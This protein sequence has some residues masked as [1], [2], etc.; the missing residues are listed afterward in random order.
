MSHKKLKEIV[1]E[2]QPNSGKSPLSSEDPQNPFTIAFCYPKDK[3]PFV[4]K[5]GWVDVEK[6]IKSQ[7]DPLV[8]HITYWWRKAHRNIVEAYNTTQK[9]H[10]EEMGKL[11]ERKIWKIYTYK[12]I[13]HVQ[14]EK[15]VLAVVR[16]LPRKWIKELNSY[17]P[18]PR[19]EHRRLIRLEVNNEY[20]E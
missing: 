4:I 9:I 16:R 17:C 11:G 2:Y 20:N 18:I 13:N 5:G 6:R 3:E 1:L 14:S 15:K 7:K 12:N 10:F 8:V 19:G